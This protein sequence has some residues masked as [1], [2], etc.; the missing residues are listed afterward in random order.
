MGRI[1]SYFGYR[2]DPFTRRIRHHDGLD[3]SAPYGTQVISAGKGVVKFADVKD[4]AGMVIIEHGER[5]PN[6][7]RSYVEN[8]VRK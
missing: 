5:L 7:I 2:R 8:R 3:I 1:M 4:Y 6:R